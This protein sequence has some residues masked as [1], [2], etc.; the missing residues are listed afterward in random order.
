MKKVL[1]STISLATLLSS[2]AFSAD[3]ELLRAALKKIEALD[4]RMSSLE[5]ENKSLRAALNKNRPSLEKPQTKSVSGTASQY[6][7][8][9]SAPAAA[10]ANSQA[11]LPAYK[12]APNLISSTPWS[13]VYAGINAGYAVGYINQ[14]SYN[15]SGGNNNG[16]S[17][18]YD[19]LND[20]FIQGGT[21]GGQFGYNHTFANHLVVGGEAD[22]SWADIN[23][24]AY[25][26]YKSYNGSGIYA[27][28]DG[29]G[30]S[31]SEYTRLGL[32]WMGTVR[33]RFGYDMGKFLPYVTGGFAYGQLSNVLSVS[34]LSPSNGSG[35]MA[36]GSNS[37]VST[38]WTLGAGAEYMVADNWSLKGE[39]LYTQLGGISV[40]INSY[41]SSLDA[42]SASATYTTID[43]SVFAFHQFRF[44][45]NYHTG[46]LGGGVAPIRASY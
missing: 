44:G 27:Y 25:S 31:G 3:E 46:W 18:S 20:N 13:G 35:T 7:T 4:S 1:F 39:Y 33:A 42:N 32:N 43:T 23:N 26:P 11:N 2:P 15:A 37:T 41:S 38:G 8:N 12:S 40:P 36:Y 10:E 5:A 28:S 34:N 14:N 22:I 17:A 9:F 24:L 45:L 19:W 6:S 21:A 30:N 29:T 16:I